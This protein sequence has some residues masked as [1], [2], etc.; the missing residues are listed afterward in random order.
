MV[1]L[2]GLQIINLKQDFFERKDVSISETSFL[3]LLKL[4]HELN[5]YM[6]LQ[7]FFIK[8]FGAR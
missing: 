4:F 6:L 7:S 8:N 1:K 5:I 2:T 3:V